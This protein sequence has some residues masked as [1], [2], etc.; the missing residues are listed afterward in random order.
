M[1]KLQRHFKTY[2]ATEKVKFVV[3]FPILCLAGV[4]GN[5]IDIMG[6]ILRWMWNFV[7]WNWRQLTVIAIAAII[8]AT[9]ILTIIRIDQTVP[10]FKGESKA[11]AMTYVYTNCHEMANNFIVAADGSVR[12]YVRADEDNIDRI[13]AVVVEYGISD[14]GSLV[15]WLLQF[16]AG[17]F[18]EAVAFHNHCWEKLDGEVGYATD[19][20]DRYK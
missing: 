19:L 7:R 2:S 5:F 10:R 1:K 16:K 17:N 14:N 20:R 11:Q 18:S 12:G 13:L 3:V 15:E 8:I 9:P 4:A 6:Y